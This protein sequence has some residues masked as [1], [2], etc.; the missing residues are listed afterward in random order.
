[1]LAVAASPVFAAGADDFN[2]VPEPESIALLG[3]GALALL[4]ARR[5]KK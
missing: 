1:L 5:V 2:V 3:I 4:I